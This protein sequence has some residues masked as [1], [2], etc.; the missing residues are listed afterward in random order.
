MSRYSPAYLDKVKGI[1]EAALVEAIDRGEIARHSRMDYDKSD[2]TYFGV[3]VT[4]DSG[5][6]SIEVD[7]V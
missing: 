3:Q 4:D 6:V 7:W 5:H 2:C 1:I